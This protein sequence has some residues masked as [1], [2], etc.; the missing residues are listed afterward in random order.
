MVEIYWSYGKTSKESFFSNWAI[1]GLGLALVVILPPGRFS[2]QR[3]WAHDVVVRGAYTGEPW[4]LLLVFYSSIKLVFFLKLYTFFPANSPFGILWPG[5]SG[6]VF[7]LF[8][9]FFGFWY[10]RRIPAIDPS[11][12]VSFSFCIFDSFYFFSS[13][14]HCSALRC[15]SWEFSARIPKV[16]IALR[17]LLTFFSTR[18]SHS[19][20]FFLIHESKSRFLI[21]YYWNACAKFN[22]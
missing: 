4:I 13:N 2:N 5:F 9:I 8:W 14:F 10:G 3:R 6:D 15:F 18:H 11:N 19:I 22:F 7:E 21:L 1:L 20:R 17:F 12:L 16:G